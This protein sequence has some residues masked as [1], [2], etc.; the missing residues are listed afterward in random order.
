V[1]DD[2]DFFVDEEAD[3]REFD[4]SYSRL[5]YVHSPDPELPATHALGGAQTTAKL[6]F[7]RSLGGLMQSSQGQYGGIVR[8]TLDHNQFL[9]IQTC[10][11]EAGFTI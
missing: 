1:D 7:A 4:S 9:F 2:D 8:Q 3:A 5:A 10:L 6:H 11:Q